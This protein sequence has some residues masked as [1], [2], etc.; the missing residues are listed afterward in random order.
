M[1]E[2]LAVAERTKISKSG[3]QWDKSELGF[4][5]SVWDKKKYMPSCSKRKEAQKHI[6]L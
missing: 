6:C 4:L 3:Y 5:A 1:S 2:Y